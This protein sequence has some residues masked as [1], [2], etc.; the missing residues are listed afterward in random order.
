MDCTERQ[1]TK[2]AREAEKLVIQT[3]KGTGIGS[4]EMDLIHLVRHN[5]GIL[6]KEVSEK[7]NM[8]KAAVARR[9]SRLEEKGYLV[10]MANP[11]DGR[12]RKLYATEKAE[13]LKTSKAQVETV[14]YEW[15]LEELSEEEKQ[16][17]SNTLHYLYTRS[18]TESRA[19]FP[20]VKALLKENGDEKQ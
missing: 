10:Q 11:E 13:A 1:M 15:L 12:S 8:D 18:R 20:H 7:L 4:E 6:Q 17:F 9:A 3:M 5:P 2:I 14:F 16:I 19:G